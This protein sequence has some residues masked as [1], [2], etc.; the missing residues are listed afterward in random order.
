MDHFNNEFGENLINY[1]DSFVLLNENLTKEKEF[2]DAVQQV[3]LVKL[4]N[5]IIETFEK[6]NNASNEFNDFQ[7]YQTSLNKNISA[8]IAILKEYTSISSTFSN[9]NK[10]L[11]LVTSHIVES[12]DFYHQFKAFLENHFSE[13][14]LRK[15]IFTSSIEQID[16]AL[17]NK[18]KELSEKT[19]TQKEF[20]NEQW[21]ST[22]DELNKDIVT[23]FSKMTEYVQVEAE[24][25]KKYIA[26]EQQSLQIIFESNKT[27]E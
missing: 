23:L 22:V 25:L 14:E 13:I 19:I 4:S 6:L 2:L 26:S 1:K 11:D 27:S 8:S 21:R 7:E 24:S 20:Y 16:N 18:L 3:G 10:N 5:Q 9:F 15:N 12:S 17:V